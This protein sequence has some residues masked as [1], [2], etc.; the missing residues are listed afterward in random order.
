MALIGMVIGVLLVILWRAPR[1][2]S[3]EPAGNGIRAGQSFSL[4]TNSAVSIESARKHFEIYPPVAGDLSFNGE[5]L[6]FKPDKSLEY[7]QSY[8]VTV[9]IGL[10]GISGLNSLRSYQQ[11]YSVSKPQ[12]L[13]LRDIDGR[14]NLWIEENQGEFIQFTDELRGIWDYSALADGSGILV[15]SRDLDGSDNL[16]LALENNGRREILNCLEFQ[17]RGGRW[18]P[19]GELIA[20]ERRRIGPD[21][22]PIEVWIL[23]SETGIS[24][25][26]HEIALGSGLF[27]GNSTGRFPRWSTDG[28]YLSYYSDDANA[29]VVLDMLGGQT[30]F[31]PANVDMMGEWS[32][33]GYKLAYTELGSYG[34][35][36]DLELD[37]DDETDIHDP[38]S[39]FAHVIV[40]DLESLERED[41][42]QVNEVDDGLPAW[43]PDGTLIAS[44]RSTGGARQIWTLALNGGGAEAMTDQPL[45][46]HTSL[47][48]SPD[49]LQ[50]A[51]MRSG[52]QGAS[53]PSGVW[54]IDPDGGEPVLV[55]EL[56]FI[57]GWRP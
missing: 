53:K 44:G 55:D 16:V 32:P 40:I 54:I 56:A 7:G 18:Q 6:I 49:G 9:S 33:A 43:K 20:Y 46:N 25:S 39:F 42:S 36:S 24:R 2:T 47:S 41:V 19:R 4:T 57:P 17:C 34:T 27:P 48:W 22:A 21:E 51:F 35:Q 30:Q 50:L 38:A 23:D 28:R 52:V 13:F 5:A 11:V 15:S 26:A 29:I 1:I 10:Q 12:L 3:W 37:E 14:T 31:F 45:A 8:T